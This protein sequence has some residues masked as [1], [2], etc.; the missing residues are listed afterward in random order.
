MSGRPASGAGA[1]Q[2]AGPAGS[3]KSRDQAMILPLVGFVL[4]MPPFASIF[5]LDLK[6]AGIP[7]TLVYLFAVWAGLIFCGWRLSRRLGADTSGEGGDR[8]D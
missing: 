2:G 6:L 4:L 1:G 5:E 8:A 3:G 7:F